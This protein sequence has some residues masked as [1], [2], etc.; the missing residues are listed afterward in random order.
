M[1]GSAPP[2][3]T[4]PLPAM[5]ASV[6]VRDR[7]GNGDHGPGLTTR[8]RPLSAP[9]AIPAARLG[10]QHRRR[11]PGISGPLPQRSL[12]RAD[13]SSP[14]G[15]KPDEETAFARLLRVAWAELSA[16]SAEAESVV[17]VPPLSQS[18]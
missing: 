10:R 17:H 15:H 18:G 4:L 7:C 9:W 2:P 5:A 8:V 13:P 14:H 12:V 11:S 1:T 16:R 6:S 3:R